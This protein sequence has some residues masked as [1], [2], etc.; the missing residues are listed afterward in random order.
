MPEGI[1][2][3]GGL[4]YIVCVTLSLSS[5]CGYPIYNNQENSLL[6]GGL[7][8]LI[9]MHTVMYSMY[10]ALDFLLAGVIER[11]TCITDII[12]MYYD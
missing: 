4:L 11:C 9:Y 3:R 8:M 5:E 12:Q 1:S 10:R 2:L 6:V 7:V